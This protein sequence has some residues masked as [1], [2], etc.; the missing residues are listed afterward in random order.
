MGYF[1]MRLKQGEL[2]T[3]CC[4]VCLQYTLVNVHAYNVVY[5]PNVFRSATY[6]TMLITVFPVLYNSGL[7]CTCICWSHVNHMLST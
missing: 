1:T 7:V 2:I 4:I 5:A 6:H 3:V